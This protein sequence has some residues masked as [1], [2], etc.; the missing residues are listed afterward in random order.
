MKGNGAYLSYRKFYKVDEDAEKELFFKE[1]KRIVKRIH[2][3]QRK[4]ATGPF[5][6]MYADWPSVTDAGAK[7]LDKLRGGGEGRITDYPLNIGSDVE[8][9]LMV[10]KGQAD[11]LVFPYENGEADIWDIMFT[12]FAEEV[13]L[14]ATDF[15]K[16][17]WYVSDEK[18]F[19]KTTNGLIIAPHDVHPILHK[20]INK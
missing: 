4:V 16:G 14:K 13:G 10:C 9:I 11:G 1:K 20:T 17:P 5:D 19:V 15:N 8:S 18:G 7:F 3:K 12:L 2:A 6:F